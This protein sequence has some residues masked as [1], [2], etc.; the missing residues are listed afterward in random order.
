VTERPWLDLSRSV[1][2]RVEA[3]LAAMTLDEK[4]AQLSSVWSSTEDTGDVAP[5]FAEPK[6]YADVTQHGIGQLTRVFGSRP[7]G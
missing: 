1:E 5:A 6:T 3:L 7:I 4:L 2:E